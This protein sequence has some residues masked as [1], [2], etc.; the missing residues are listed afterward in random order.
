MLKSCWLKWFR[1]EGKINFFGLFFS[2][3]DENCCLL[4]TGSGFVQLKLFWQWHKKYSTISGKRQAVWKSI[5]IFSQSWD[6]PETDL[7]EVGLT[8]Y[9]V[10]ALDRPWSSTDPCIAGGYPDGL[11]GQGKGVLCEKCVQRRQRK[12]GCFAA[13]RHGHQGCVR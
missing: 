1:R 4:F 12:D 9:K 7:P 11:Q 8:N 6:L 13:S 3:E 10:I 2:T 5:G